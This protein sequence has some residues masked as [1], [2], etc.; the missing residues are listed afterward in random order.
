MEE[1]TGFSHLLAEQTVNKVRLQIAPKVEHSADPKSISQLG[2]LYAK[3]TGY[4]VRI[5]ERV[6]GNTVDYEIFA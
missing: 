1:P 4:Y 2:K 6:E 5:K 3:G